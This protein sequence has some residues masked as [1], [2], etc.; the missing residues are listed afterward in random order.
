[1]NFSEQTFDKLAAFESYYDTA[2]HGDWCPNPGRAALAAMCD[3]LDEHDKKRNLR[4]FS[5]A[6]CLLRIVKRTGYLYFADKA[7]REALKASEAAKPGKTPA[8]KTTAATAKKTGK[9]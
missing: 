8:K 9:K 7:E 6:S 4:N 5:C 3:A 1:M 2:I